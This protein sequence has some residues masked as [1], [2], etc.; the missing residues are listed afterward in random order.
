MNRHKISFF[1]VLSWIITAVF[2]ALLG[3]YIAIG[4]DIGA[5]E[6]NDSEV[7]VKWYLDNNVEIDPD[8]HSFYSAVAEDNKFSIHHDVEQ[9]VYNVELAFETDFSDADVFLN[10]KK[11]YSTKD[12]HDED[13]SA[14][15]SFEA[16]TPKLHIVDFERVSEGDVIRIDVQLYYNDGTDG[17]GGLVYGEANDVTAALMKNDSLEFFLCAVLL[18]FCIIMLVVRFSSRDNVI[19]S[20]L[21]HMAFFAFFSTVFSFFSSPQ[22]SMETGFSSDTTYILYF[23]SFAIMFLPL[24]VFFAENV[25]LRISRNFLFVN[26][27]FQTIFILASVTLALLGIADLHTTHFYIE[28]IGCIQFVLILIVLIIDFAK[29][30]ERRNSDLTLLIIYAI[31]LAIAATEHLINLRNAIPMMWVVS[32]LYLVIAV[33]VVKVKAASVQLESVTET[34]KIGKLAFKDSLTGVGNT[35]AF[36]KKMSHLEVVKINYKVIAIIQ[37]DINNL[38]TINDNLGHEMGDKLITDGSAMISRIFGK[39]GDVYRTGGDEFVAII[40]GD[41]AASLCDKAIIDFERAMDDY[42]SDKTHKFILQVAYG[43]EYYHSDTDKRYVSLHQIQKNADEKMYNKKREMKAAMK[44]AI[45]EN[46]IVRTDQNIR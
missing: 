2:I 1:S 27:V 43:V 33:A 34:A 4:I 44:G 46:V 13:A 8:D 17:I 21:E 16:P 29:K 14:F 31:F 40:C 32:C 38:K 28:I 22:L 26:S 35:A 25:T 3:Y 36:R 45:A 19:T 39:I 18:S 9:T 5:S 12:D 11:I 20:G 15:F 42:N 6:A 37:F 7:T 23:L 10:N 24:I 30:I 41:N